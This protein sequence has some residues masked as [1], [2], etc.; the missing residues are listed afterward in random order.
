[1][2]RGQFEHTIDPKG[3]LSI[4]AGFR[5]EIQRRSDNPPILT[6]QRYHLELY[7]YEDWQLI[8][9]QLIEKS[10]LQP[11]V[12]AL[13]RFMVSGASECPI[14]SQGR[15]LIPKA[16]RE[17]AN[18]ESKVTVAGVLTK[19]EIWNADRFEAEMQKTLINFESIQ[20]SVDRGSEH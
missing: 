19:I 16:L 7:P 10:A 15:I 6:R 18:L 1:M 5:M 4:P 3:R 2:F 13:Q 11:D 20:Q 9:Q 17:H 12:Q 14:D 8:E